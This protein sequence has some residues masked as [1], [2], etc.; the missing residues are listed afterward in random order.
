MSIEDLIVDRV[1]GGML[2][3]LYPR[4][5]GAG[6]RRLMLVAESLWDFLQS[7]GPDDEWEDRKGFLLADL[8][9]F[10]DLEQIG[11]KYLFLLSPSREGVWEIRSTRPNPSIRVLG[12]FIAR[13]VFVATNYALR[14]E[15]GGWKSRR[16]RDVKLMSRTVWAWL[17]QQQQPLITTDVTNVVS[18]AIDGRYFKG[19]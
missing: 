17:F 2:F 15:L 11:P 6:P 3:P 16:W 19:D 9:A 7:A 4:A 10:A 18:G 13:D 12:R 14:D 8:E 1:D 5:A